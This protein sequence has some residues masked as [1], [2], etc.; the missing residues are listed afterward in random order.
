MDASFWARQPTDPGLLLNN[1]AILSVL[2]YQS[3]P[4]GYFRNSDGSPFR[5]G[6]AL[7]VIPS[8]VNYPKTLIWE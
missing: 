3:D 7:Q 6:D 4:I 2:R 5:V 1:A 8:S